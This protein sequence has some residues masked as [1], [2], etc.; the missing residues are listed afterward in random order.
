MI[1]ESLG[2]YRVVK[3]L[4][5]GGMG[6]V[7]LAQ[8]ERLNRQVA[9]KVLPD[10]AANDPDAQRRLLA[11]ARSASQLNHPHIC[12][13]YDIG[14]AAGRTFIAME[15]VDGGALSAQIP[16]EGLAV[17]V[18]IRYGLQ[19]SEALAHA[20]ERGIIH[21]DLKSSNI[22]IQNDGRAKVMDFGLA[23]RA[24]EAL[25]AEETR[26]Q[27]APTDGGVIVGTLHYLAPEC[28]RGDAASMASDVWSL[29]VVLY[30]MA[31][32]ELPFHGTTA[33]E[34]TAAA[35]HQTPPPL[36]DRIPVTLR[37]VIERCLSKDPKL[38][39]R[40]ASE[41][42]A[43]LEAVQTGA[44]TAPRTRPSRKM[45]YKGQTEL[46]GKLKSLTITS[47]LGAAGF[48]FGS[49]VGHGGVMRPRHWVVGI[50]G[51]LLFGIAV[52]LLTVRAL[53]RWSFAIYPDKIRAKSKRR[54][55]DIRFEDIA[56]MELLSFDK[57]LFTWRNTLL[58]LRINAHPQYAKLGEASSFQWGEQQDVVRIDCP[59]AGR[60]KGYFLDMDNAARF[61]E[62]LQRALHTY[63]QRRATSSV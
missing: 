30:E 61:Y 59:G 33:F 52:Q 63:R 38:R 14:E 55:I 12:T 43:A 13:V 28:L 24:P 6:V 10:A 40:S 11:E 32:G 49:Y 17:E 46:R 16:A 31:A 3:K 21:R 35:L 50:V 54:N 34:V 26:S 53:K 8:D 29:G 19:I 48:F 9:L 58:S 39:Y 41:L 45:L 47:L 25:A 37:A 1:G 51:G 42:R 27:L 15:Y 2:P 5:A 7:Y 20:H 22:M 23:T 18:V 62:T 44:A 57:K 4:G 56:G 60:L 36:P